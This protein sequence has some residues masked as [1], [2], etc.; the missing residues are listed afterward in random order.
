MGFWRNVSPRRAIRDLRD[1]LA[2]PSRHR[3][4]FMALSAAMT[5]S[6]FGVMFQEGGK[7]PPDPPE[8]IYFPSFLP[9]R[10]D[11]EIIAGNIEATARMKREEAEQ[12]AREEEV[13]RAYKVLG[14]ATGVD[15]ERAYAEGTRQRAAEK[16]ALQ[17][18]REALLRSYGGPREN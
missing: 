12:E 2:A 1:Q 11:D 13:R 14:D 9:G 3:W 17:E 4:R 7:G 18:K 8:I 5:L 10:T 16:K 15:T 6:L